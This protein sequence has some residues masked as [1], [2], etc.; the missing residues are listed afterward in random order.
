MLDAFD[1]N[2]V[3]DTLDPVEGRIQEFDW[4]ELYGRLG[5]GA[6][7]HEAIHSESSRAV[8]IV[9]GWLVQGVETH[10]QDASRLIAGR[11]AALARQIDPGL[12]KDD[13]AGRVLKRIR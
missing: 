4:E 7:D 5:E 1:E 6:N 2:R 3:A 12:F 8:K 9:L 11:V 13:A 10:Q